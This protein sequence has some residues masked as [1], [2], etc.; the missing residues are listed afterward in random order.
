MTDGRIAKDLS[1]SLSAVL[2]SFGLDNLELVTDDPAV[3]ERILGGV[4]KDFS[5]K[6]VLGVDCEDVA[7]SDQWSEQNPYIPLIM[8]KGEV[9]LPAYFSDLPSD[10]IEGV[11]ARFYRK[12]EVEEAAGNHL[13]EL[14]ER[15]CR[16]VLG[17]EGY[18]Q[19]MLVKSLPSHLR[20]RR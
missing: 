4:L 19:F 20:N 16:E 5:W 3:P 17:E 12:E 13:S 7:T 14:L 2:T 15:Y 8:Q 9:A 11:Q 10:N 6:V 18:K 1:W